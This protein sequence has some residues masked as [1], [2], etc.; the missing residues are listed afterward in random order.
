MVFTTRSWDLKY[1]GNAAEEA[2]QT[3]NQ[4]QQLLPHILRHIPRILIQKRKREMFDGQKRRLNKK[5]TLETIVGEHFFKQRS[6][7]MKTQ[8]SRL[9]RSLRRNLSIYGT[10]KLQGKP[11][12]LSWYTF[13]NVNVFNIVVFLLPKNCVC[14]C[15]SYLNMQY[16]RYKLKLHL[17]INI[18]CSGYVEGKHVPQ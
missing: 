13:L 14:R 15:F 16:S 1:V 12:N 10:A 9:F 7:Y 11:P 3:D 18:G 2:S 8:I 4:D 17:C 5:T 6:Y